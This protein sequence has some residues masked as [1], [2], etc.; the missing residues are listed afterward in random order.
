M[1]SLLLTICYEMCD[2][3]QFLEL[4]EI[5]HKYALEGSEFISKECILVGSVENGYLH[6]RC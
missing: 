2:L 3:Y 1:L 4:E 6:G 5:A